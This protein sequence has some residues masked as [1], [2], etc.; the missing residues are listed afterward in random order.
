MR[1]IIKR[2]NNGRRYDL[3]TAQEIAVVTHGLPGACSFDVERLLK[4][5]NGENILHGRGGLL[6]PYSSSE[7]GERFIRLTM[8]EARAWGKKNMS[9]KAFVKEFGK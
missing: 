5:R 7:G 4:K 2:I 9:Q 8:E 3:D 1:D 6:S